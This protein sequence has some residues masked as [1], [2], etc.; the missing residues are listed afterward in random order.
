MARSP[1]SDVRKNFWKS[2]DCSLVEIP[3]P[4]SATSTAT[5][6]F[7]EKTRT[8]TLPPSGVNLTAFEIR[9]SSSCPR[10]PGSPLTGGTSSSV[11]SSLTAWAAARGAAAPTDSRA[12]GL[13]RQRCEVRVLEGELELSRSEPR[14]EEQVVDEPFEPRG[15]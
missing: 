10:R 9:L 15:V 3:I 8:S 14:H 5:S 12:N 1:A 4:V 2:C 7:C 11:H 13:A 6:P